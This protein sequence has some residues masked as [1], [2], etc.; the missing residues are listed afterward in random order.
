MIITHIC[1][2]TNEY[3]YYLNAQY[4]D[5]GEKFNLIDIVSWIS[6]IITIH[7]KG[8]AYNHKSR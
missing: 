2:T 6:M 8:L 4:N 7:A 3:G 5:M 1:K